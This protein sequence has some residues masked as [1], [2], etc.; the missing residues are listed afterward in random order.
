MECE[1]CKTQ[2]EDF[3][4]LVKHLRYKCRLAFTPCESIGCLHQ[5]PRALVF[6][7]G[8]TSY[9]AKHVLKK[10][11]DIILTDQAG[12]QGFDGATTETK[13]T[14]IN[15]PLIDRPV[16]PYFDFALGVELYVLTPN[17]KWLLATIVKREFDD[18]QLFVT[19]SLEHHSTF[20]L[21]ERV[22]RFCVNTDLNRYM[23]CYD[24]MD[25]HQNAGPAMDINADHTRD[26][27]TLSFS[28]Q[29]LQTMFRHNI[30]AEQLPKAFAFFGLDPFNLSVN[31]TLSLQETGEIV[32]IISMDDSYYH[33]HVL[34]SMASV[35]HV[36]R[37]F[38]LQM[39]APVN[40]TVTDRHLVKKTLS[41]YSKVTKTPVIRCMSA[42]T[43]N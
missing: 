7:N 31:H 38:A 3:S 1:L 19:V 33:L 8:H 17:K 5:F 26:M 10:N 22:Q 16:D 21:R 27:I 28:N 39:F 25:V 4:E 9:K 42:K 2:M 14:T 6:G 12:P 18:E 11:T 43:V 23:S 37:K 32:Q 41:F 35:L 34:H 40:C 36:P 13:Q 30:V 29:N 15:C 24:W 20:S